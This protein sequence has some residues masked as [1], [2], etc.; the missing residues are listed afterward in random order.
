MTCRRSDM[1]QC[2][3]RLASIW[4]MSAALGAEQ[5]FAVAV[6]AFDRRG[7]HAQ[8]APAERCGVLFDIPAYHGVNG[9]IADDPLGHALGTGLVRCGERLEVAAVVEGKDVER[10]RLRAAG[11]GAVEVLLVE[12]VSSHC[13]KMENQA[14][15]S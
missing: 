15:G 12:V 14:P 5:E 6:T 8:H 9:R 1:Y 11:G 3:S 2:Q 10:C 13:L 4:V 7:D